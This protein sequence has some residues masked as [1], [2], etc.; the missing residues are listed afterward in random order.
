MKKNLLFFTYL[1][2]LKCFLRAKIHKSFTA[3]PAKTFQTLRLLFIKKVHRGTLLGRLW[4][5]HL[6]S[7]Q[8]IQ[9]QSLRV[10]LSMKN[11]VGVARTY[12]TMRSES[13]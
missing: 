4:L 13:F 2:L 10:T 5:Q 1:A 9:V 12:R 6:T 11:V 3:Q 7:H 8:G